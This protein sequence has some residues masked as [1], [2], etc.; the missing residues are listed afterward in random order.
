MSGAKRKEQRWNMAEN[1]QIVTEEKSDIK[2]INTDPM[3][4]LEHDVNDKSKIVKL[5]PTLVELEESKLQWKDDFDLNSMLR[6]KLR[7]SI[8]YSVDLIFNYFCYLLLG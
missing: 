8:L 3:F 5:M 2:R 7:V 4:K 6:K 1:E